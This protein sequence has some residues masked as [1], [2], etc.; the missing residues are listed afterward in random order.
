MT[1]SP[2]DDER[3]ALIVLRARLK[4]RLSPWAA[5]A[6]LLGRVLASDQEDKPRR[7]ACSSEKG[8]I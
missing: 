3:E 6:S 7:G 4:G 1:M 8:K 5:S 2:L